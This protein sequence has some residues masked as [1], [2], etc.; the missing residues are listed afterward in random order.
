MPAEQSA[1][2]DYFVK[3]G[4]TN[5]YLSDDDLVASLPN[6][7]TTAALITRP[8]GLDSTAEGLETVGTVVLDPAAL[9]VELDTTSNELEPGLYDAEWKFTDGASK[10]FRLP[11]D[12]YKLLEV[13][14]QIPEG[15]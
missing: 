3:S 5:A 11:A 15:T 6:W 14:A 10:E 9:S 4:I 2:P 13:V 8:K 7:V 12:K 1:T